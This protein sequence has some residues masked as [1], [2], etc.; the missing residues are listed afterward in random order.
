MRSVS[1]SSLRTQARQRADAESSD[2]SQAFV[3]DTEL[4]GYIN[5]SIAE[6]YDLMIEA[7]GD[8][9]FAV[10]SSFATL[11]GDDTYPLPSDF[12]RLSGVDAAVGGFRYTL[13]LFPFG[14][15]NRFSNLTAPGWYR[16]ARLFYRLRNADIVFVPIPDAAYQITLWYIP[17]PPILVADGD[18]FDFQ[19][20]WEEYVIIDAAIKMQVKEESDTSVLQLGKQQLIARIR[21]AAPKRDDGSPQ[22]VTDVFSRDGEGWLW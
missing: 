4:N 17:N 12:Y 8:E 13:H 9:Y 16:G 15:R 3:P 10:S 2:T 18:S 11:S 21:G 14:E 1:L 5:N 22:L 19:G 7:N 6:L 20:G